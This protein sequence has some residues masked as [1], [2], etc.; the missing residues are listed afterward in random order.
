MLK[1]LHRFFYLLRYSKELEAMAILR[2]GTTPN[3]PEWIDRLPDNL[4]I[5]I[6]RK[7]MENTGSLSDPEEIK[8]FFRIITKMQE[9]TPIL[10]ERKK[11]MLLSII[12]KELILNELNFQ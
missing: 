10:F 11:A 3:S 5:N 9:R 2:Y 7:Y 6:Y 4:I 1:S 8:E 12:R